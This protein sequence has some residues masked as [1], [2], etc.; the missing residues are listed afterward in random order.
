[1]KK[2]IEDFKPSLPNNRLNSTN[3]SFLLGK[4]VKA[5]MMS[6]KKKRKIPT[7]TLRNR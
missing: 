4:S 2:S 3:K 1:M 5:F 7:Y 6:F